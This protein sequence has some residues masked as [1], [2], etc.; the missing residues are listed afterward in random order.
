MDQLVS[1]ETG[2]ILQE[3]IMYDTEKILPLGTMD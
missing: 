1:L 3:D 2:R